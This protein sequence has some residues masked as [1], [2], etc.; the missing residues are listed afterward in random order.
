MAELRRV[1]NDFWFRPESPLNLAVARLLLVVSALWVVLSRPDLPSILD[2]PATMWLWVSPERHIR[3]L[4]LFNVGTERVLWYAL[5]VALILTLVGLATR[6]MALASG[7]LLYHFAPLESIFRSPNPYLLGF[8]TPCV[9]LILV[10][11]SASGGA[12]RHNSR[13]SA[14]QHRWPVAGVQFLLCAMYFFAGYSKL[15]ATGL[16]WLE[17][18]NIRNTILVIDQALGFTARPSLGLWI[19]DHPLLCGMIS[20]TGLIFELIFPLVLISRR[21]R[22]VL[23][24]L[25]FLFHVLNAV[26]FRIYFQ[27]ILLLLVFIDWQPLLAKRTMA[28]AS[29]R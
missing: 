12:F 8:T 5:H 22:S 21:A 9:G 24:P 1:W 25:A 11:V 13:E 4:L 20:V 3:F 19:A 16:A 15:F 28:T 17:P 18:R 27:S 6:W 23:V 10:A 29:T 26:V 7:L 2:F 14:W